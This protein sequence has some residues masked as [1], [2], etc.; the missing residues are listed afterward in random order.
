VGWYVG[1]LDVYGVIPSRQEDDQGDN[2]HG[3]YDVKRYMQASG[4]LQG[5]R[6]NVLPSV[7]AAW[8]QR[9]LPPIGRQISLALQDMWRSILS[10]ETIRS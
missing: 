1:V 3:F 9:F 4:E 2:Y 6:F 10:V 7:R 5:L 8:R